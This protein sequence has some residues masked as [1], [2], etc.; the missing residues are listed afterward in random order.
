MGVPEKH[1]LTAA[2][3]LGN[4]LLATLSLGN[5]SALSSE[6]QWIKGLLQ[7]QIQN[8]TNLKKFL[9]AYTS[10]IDSVMGKDGLPISTWLRA[11]TN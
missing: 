2:Q 11:Q 3:Q 10:A 1:A 8:E 5:I 6:I 9:E 4:N 7:E